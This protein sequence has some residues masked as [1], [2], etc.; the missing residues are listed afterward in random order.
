MK[1]HFTGRKLTA[2]NKAAAFIEVSISLS[3]YLAIMAA[4]MYGRGFIL[5]KITLSIY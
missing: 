5:C 3:L 1:D 2:A 4:T